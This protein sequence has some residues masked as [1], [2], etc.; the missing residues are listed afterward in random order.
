MCITAKE[1]NKKNGREK[2]SANAPEEDRKRHQV[3]GRG[4]H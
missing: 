2:A 1:M 4:N 3:I